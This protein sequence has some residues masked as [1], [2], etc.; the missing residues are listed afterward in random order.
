MKAHC[1]YKMEVPFSYYLYV[2]QTKNYTDSIN[3]LAIRSDFP[4]AVL[5]L[6]SDDIE[7]KED[8]G[9]PTTEL[10]IS[11]NHNFYA[12]VKTSIICCNLN[13]KNCNLRENAGSFL[14]ENIS[15]L[16]Y[17]NI[18]K[19]Q[20]GYS[21]PYNMKTQHLIFSSIGRIISQGEIDTYVQDKIST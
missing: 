20:N 17:N 4:E 18:T 6:Y 11:I 5:P 2:I 9:Y 13:F 15:V 12:S 19:I 3:M 7:Y 14:R 16:C 21:I 1:L 8:L 10:L